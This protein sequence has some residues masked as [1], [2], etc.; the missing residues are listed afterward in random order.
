MAINTKALT[1]EAGYIIVTE[2]NGQRTKYP[3][4][5]LA[6]NITTGVTYAQ[7]QAITALSNLLAVLIRTLID[8]EIL[9]ESFLED[10]EYTL[11][12][13]TEAIE[14]MGGDYGD[15]DISVEE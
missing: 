2:P 5:V 14:Q 3:V 6:S 9:D 15:P 10:G 13:I 7:V 1:F 12:S 11:E 8:R 4:E